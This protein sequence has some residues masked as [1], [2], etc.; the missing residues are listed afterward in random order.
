M[1]VF[2][3]WSGA[4]SK[5]VAELMRDWIRCVLQVTRPWISTR[6]L[7]RGSIWFGELNEQLK[8]TGVGIICL[9]QE[10]KNR[11]WILFEAGALMKGLTVNRVCTFLID[12]ETK[13]IEDPLA[14][15]NHTFPTKSSMFSLVDTLNNQLGIQSLDQRTLQNVFETYWPQFK[16]KFD[17]ILKTVE[18]APEAKP[19]EDTDILAE[20]LANTRSLS[21]RIS[22]LESNRDDIEII[23]NYPSRS[24]SDY[25][26]SNFDHQWLNSIR[27][28][29]DTPS[30]T[31][32]IKDYINSLPIDD[33]EKYELMRWAN[34]PIPILK[35]A[36]E[37]IRNMK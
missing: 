27:A 1:K 6:D 16:E 34:I 26:L 24:I 31:Q 23:H 2:I 9:T 36:Q 21:N 28:M 8:D 20:I 18:S 3:S 17:Y 25:I 11:P 4:R 10:N 13:D 19:R 37:V 22:L 5:E 35:N 15:F 30:Q 14:Q 32:N 33:I 12:L 29:K 7:G